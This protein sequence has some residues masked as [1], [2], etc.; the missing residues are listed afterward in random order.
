MVF[1][2]I[3]GSPLGHARWV[4]SLR[5]C[6]GRTGGR[7]RVGAC[8]VRER[9]VGHSPAADEFERSATVAS[10]NIQFSLL[11]SHFSVRVHGSAFGLVLCFRKDYSLDE[12]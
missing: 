9:P 5:Q 6:H 7:Q 1:D 10:D 3:R 11:G 12:R 4:R 8:C 2:P